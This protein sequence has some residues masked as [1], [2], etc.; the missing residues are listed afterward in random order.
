M[1]FFCCLLAVKKNIWMGFGRHKYVIRQ[2]FYYYRELFLQNTLFCFYIQKKWMDSWTL[3]YFDKTMRMCVWHYVIAAVQNIIHRSWNGHY[4]DKSF[5]LNA[6][7]LFCTN[8]SP[9][10]ICSNYYYKTPSKQFLQY[11]Y[12]FH[13]IKSKK[14]MMR[15]VLFAE[16]ESYFLDTWKKLL[17]HQF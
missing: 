10:F 8:V 16:S 12:V 2:H 13:V 3:N 4:G 14:S 1:G 9:S 11:L 15:N 17:A 5:I 6:Y 7:N